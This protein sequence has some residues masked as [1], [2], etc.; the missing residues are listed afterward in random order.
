MKPVIVDKVLAEYIEHNSNLMF[1]NLSRRYAL[2]FAAVI[3]V[4]IGLGIKIVDL[5]TSI[6]YDEPSFVKPNGETIT[7]TPV[8][9]PPMS[10]STVKDIAR[11][12]TA[13]VM[14]IDF[15]QIKLDLENSK[16]L[17]YS[18]ETYERDYLEPL[19]GSH[20]QEGSLQ[21]IAA[22]NLVISA[23]S[24]PSSQPIISAVYEENGVSFYKIK[25]AF[26]QSLKTPSGN[27]PIR[28]GTAYLTL[29]EVPRAVNINGLQIYSL[30]MKSR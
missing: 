12:Y 15:S 14:S 23:S 8:Y 3:A 26:L 30:G 20:E 9:R 7:L 18:E 25:V 11:Q 28:R 19:M 24:A 4:L 1:A 5:G 16:K 27:D 29:I 21:W 13:E 17:F 22:N 2:I 10:L 6:N